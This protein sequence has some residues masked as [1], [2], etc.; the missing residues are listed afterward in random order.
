MAKYGV[1]IPIA[2]YI[3]FEVEASS[4]EEAAEKALQMSWTDED[5]Q[6]LDSYERLVSG[7]VAHITRYTVHAYPIKD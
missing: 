4:K 6:E 2:G 5:I 7:N 3:Y 1:E